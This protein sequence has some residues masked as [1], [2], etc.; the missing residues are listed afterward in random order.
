MGIGKLRLALAGMALTACLLVSGCGFNSTFT[1]PDD[2]N[3][4]RFTCEAGSAYI[5]T[6][7]KTGVQYLAWRYTNG[8]GLEVLV[9]RDG[10]PLLAEAD[11]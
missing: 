2:E 3:E 6:D 11:E 5:I 7:T 9:D 1:L 8:G 4:G 10:K